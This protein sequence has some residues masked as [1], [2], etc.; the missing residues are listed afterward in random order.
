MTSYR[1]HT[2]DLHFLDTPQLIASYALIGPTSVALIETGPGS[3][4][5]N[6]LRGLRDIGVQ[7][8]DVRDVLVTHIHLDHA[9][10]AGWWAR[11]GATIHVHTVGAPHLMEPSKLIA[12]ATRIYGDQMDRLWG[13]ILPVPPERL[14][15]LRDGDVI[16]A[17]GATITVID[18]PG[19]ARHHHCF[20]IGDIAFTGDAAGVRLAVYD[21][22]AVHTPPP[23]F[24]L[25]AWHTTLS[26]LAALDLRT[27]Y[28]THFGAVADPADHFRRFIPLLDE[29]AEFV[30]ARLSE[31]LNRDEIIARYATWYADRAG[32]AGLDAEALRQYAIV[33]DVPSCVDGISRYWM[34]KQPALSPSANRPRT[35]P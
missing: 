5:P 21:W 11:Q 29:C 9:G 28:P 31:G 34:K 32:A 26:R 7:P 12:S 24:D 10:G 23:E 18:S 27:I 14:R 15:A 25:D 30:R 17:A 4:L 13:E 8:T 33:N 2:I 16:Q 6:L 1:L 19:H 20:Q 35:A 3:T 22:P